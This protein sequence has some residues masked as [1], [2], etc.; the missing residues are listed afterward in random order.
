MR[1]NM[2]KLW[3]Y[4]FVY[5][6]RIGLRVMQSNISSRLYLIMIRKPVVIC[7]F[8]HVAIHIRIMAQSTIN[9]CSMA[10]LKLKQ[11]TTYER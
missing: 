8:G 10:S 1:I 4:F 6:C 2:H 7:Y 9:N 11:N 3:L 5:I